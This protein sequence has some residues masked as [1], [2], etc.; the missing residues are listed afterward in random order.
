MICHQS[1]HEG[2]IVEIIQKARFDEAHRVDAIII[3]PGAYG[4]TSIAIR[5]ALAATALPFIEVH[6]SNVHAREEYRRHSYLSDI[7]RGV[8]AGLGSYGYQAALQALL[9]GDGL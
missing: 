8:I 7:A 1:N 9:G 6:I 3:N 4:H 5:D 2:E